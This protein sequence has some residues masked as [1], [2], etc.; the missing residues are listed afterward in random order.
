ML[1]HFIYRHKNGCLHIAHTQFVQKKY[2]IFYFPLF[3]PH[4]SSL[5]FSQKGEENMSVS[6]IGVSV[7]LGIGWMGRYKEEEIKV[8]WDGTARKAEV[9]IHFWEG[10][11][12]EEGKESGRGGEESCE[13]ETAIF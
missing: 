6:W 11:A 10:Y 7:W 13:G 5:V 9:Y 1:I 2:H 12:E 3:L 8:G 4:I